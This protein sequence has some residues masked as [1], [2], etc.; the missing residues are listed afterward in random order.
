MTLP[1]P[2]LQG[3]VDILILHALVAGPRHGYAISEWLEG[4]SGGR[5]VIEDAALYTAL[6][7]MEDRGWVASEWALSEKGKRAKFYHL[8]APG[9][10]ELRARVKSWEQYV[11]TVSKVLATGSA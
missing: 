4:A 7:K 3:T 1:T 8:R 2:Y 6:H 10:T 11:A 9:R 5:I